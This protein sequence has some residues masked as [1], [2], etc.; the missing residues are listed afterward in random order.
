MKKCPKC[1]CDKFYV[2]A[3]VMQ[4][5]KVDGNGMFIKTVED[6]VQVVHGP[7]SYDIWEC[8]ECGYDAEGTEFEVDV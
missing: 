1:G 7:T 3:H 8:W 5:W 6:C 2:T 4:G